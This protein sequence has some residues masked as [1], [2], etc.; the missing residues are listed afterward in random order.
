L[1]E[2]AHY[3]PARLN[4]LQPTY[5]GQTTTVAGIIMA[6]RIAV[7]KRG[8]RIGIASIED[9]AGKLDITLFSEALENYGDL[10]QKDQ[11]IIATG[12][13]PNDDFS[14]GL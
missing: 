12:A 14:G 4:E 9:R 8:N 3:A 13:V 2:L 7:T 10:L 1:K 6:T 11:I 5:R